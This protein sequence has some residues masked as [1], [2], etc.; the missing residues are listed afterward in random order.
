MLWIIQVIQRGSVFIFFLVLFLQNT[1]ARGS[2]ALYQNPQKSG[3]FI[4]SQASQQAV[5]RNKNLQA[6]PRALHR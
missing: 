2:Y 5:L 3:A 6:A 4:L 1:A